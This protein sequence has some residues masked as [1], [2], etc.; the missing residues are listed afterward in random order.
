M[1]NIITGIVIVFLFGSILREIRIYIKQQ[2]E[3]EDLDE[4]IE[5]GKDLSV[6][7]ERVNYKKQNDVVQ[8]IINELEKEK[9]D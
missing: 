4:E 5:R 9:N 7:Y 6:K 1:F 2:K 8:K 3:S